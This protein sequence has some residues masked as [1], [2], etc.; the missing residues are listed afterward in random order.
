MLPR[1]ISFFNVLLWQKCLVP[2]LVWA[3]EACF[4]HPGYLWTHEGASS[5]YEYPTATHV[6]TSTLLQRPLLTTTQHPVTTIAIV[7]ANSKS[8]NGRLAAVMLTCTAR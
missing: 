4:F 2:T 7:K 3:C 5:T 6:Q 8:Q 1:S